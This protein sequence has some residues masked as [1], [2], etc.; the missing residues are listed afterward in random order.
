MGNDEH[1]P[2]TGLFAEKIN[3]ELLLRAL[4]EVHKENPPV[5][6]GDIEEYVSNAGVECHRNTIINRLNKLEDRGEIE[7]Q[8]VRARTKIW[9]RT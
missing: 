7:S 2:E 1:D 6:T 4:D 9:S 3:D 5:T 8:T